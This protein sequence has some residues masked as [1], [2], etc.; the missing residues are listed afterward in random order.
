LS[1]FQTLEFNQ[2]LAITTSQFSCGLV[3][4][5]YYFNQKIEYKMKNVETLNLPGSP[6]VQVQQVNEWW[7]RN[8][9]ESP[10]WKS[11]TEARTAN[12]R[13]QVLTNEPGETDY[14]EIDACGVKAMWA[15]PK[16]ANDKKVILCFH[17]G[18]YFIGSMYTH[19]KMYAH[20]AKRIGC[21]ALIINY[22]LAPEH[23]FPTQINESIK[24]YQWLLEQGFTPKD[25]AFAG[26]SAGGGLL[27]SV[28]LE[29][30]NKSIPQPVAGM[31]MSPWFDLEAT[32][33]SM[34]TNAEIDLIF[35]R[36]WIKSMGRSYLG[37][38]GNEKDPV[39]SP[40]Y[41]NLDGLPPLYLH[42][43]GDE[44]LLDDSIRLA[45]L[46]EQ[47]GTMI[48]VAVFPGMQHSFQMAAGNAPES[49]ESLQ[50]FASWVKPLLGLTT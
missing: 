2:N 29:L 42:V 9:I 28:M 11:V 49:D 36:E 5:Y 19:R 40:L 50:K 27:V 31:A 30:K 33:E 21:K 37:E 41:S 26:D 32:S 8:A 38:H 3:A 46:G 23:T 4:F 13:W 17:G 18:G 15:V 39:A 16:E 22:S 45:M 24:V 47:S 1:I 48:K 10:K 14:F 35:S 44:V 12:E 7:K 34:S 6:S 25:I 20:L 43:G